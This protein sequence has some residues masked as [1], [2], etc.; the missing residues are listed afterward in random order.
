M[1]LEGEPHVREYTR[2]FDELRAAALSPRRTIQLIKS[3]VKEY[4]R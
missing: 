2:A 1:Y 4:A 3:V